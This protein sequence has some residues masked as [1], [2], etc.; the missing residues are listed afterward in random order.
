[1]TDPTL[2]SFPIKSGVLYT[3][4]HAPANGIGCEVLL[5][6]ISSRYTYL[7]V[8]CGEH[9]CYNQRPK[10]RHMFPDDPAPHRKAI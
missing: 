4:A 8:A 7:C 5:R 10:F 1:M 2:Q 9:S 6:L 3:Q